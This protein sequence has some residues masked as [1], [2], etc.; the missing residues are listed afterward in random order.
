MA[1]LKTDYV[2][3][4][5]DTDVNT[6]RTYNLVDA[7]GNLIYEGIKIRETTVLSTTGD[8]YGALEINEQN[9]AINQ[10]NADLSALSI[11]PQVISTSSGNTE[12]YH[13]CTTSEVV[14]VSI[15]TKCDGADGGA[16]IELTRN[17]TAY[18]LAY[19]NGGTRV[20]ASIIFKAEEGDVI[21]L[22]WGVGTGGA[23]VVKTLVSNVTFS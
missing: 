8:D 13:T 7:N 12:L 4:V 19:N 16:L 18:A 1:D 11:T 14:N 3:D 15:T 9:E 10:I 23:S 5:L 6:E 20:N 17:E 22:F 21:R 2:N